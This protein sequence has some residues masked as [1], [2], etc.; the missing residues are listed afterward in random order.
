MSLFTRP[1][2]V[3]GKEDLAMSNREWSDLLRFVGTAFL[4]LADLL[5]RF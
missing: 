1:D 4:V 5:D 2:S 3:A